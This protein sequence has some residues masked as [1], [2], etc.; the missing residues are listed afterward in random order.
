MWEFEQTCNITKAIFMDRW[1]SYLTPIATAFHIEDSNN[2]VEILTIKVLQGVSKFY[3]RKE[4]KSEGNC[5]VKMYE[6]Y[7]T[8]EK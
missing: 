3:S 1:L 4:H 7:I 5:V 8:G 2:D 6:V